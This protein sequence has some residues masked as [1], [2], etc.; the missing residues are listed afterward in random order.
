MNNHCLRN[1]NSAF[2]ARRVFELVKRRLPGLIAE[3]VGDPG[4]AGRQEQDKENICITGPET[5]IQVN[6]RTYSV[7][8]FL[9]HMATSAS[10]PID[11][12]EK[13]LR[14]P[15]PHI[16]AAV[17]ENQKVSDAMLWLLVKDE[18]PTVRYQ[19]AENPHLPLDILRELC[20]DDNPYVSCRAEK[21]LERMAAAAEAR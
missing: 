10:S 12:I 13:M 9:E 11:V 17:A 14:H 16:R 1:A 5:K 3:V 6:S 7:H 20:Q 19:L 4:V 18:D 21:T 15:Q 8:A 2:V